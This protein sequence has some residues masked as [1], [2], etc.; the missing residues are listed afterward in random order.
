[1]GSTVLHRCIVS[2]NEPEMTACDAMTVAHSPKKR[3][4]AP[5]G[6]QVIERVVAGRRI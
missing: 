3:D 1:M 2:E 5:V 6:G 4:R